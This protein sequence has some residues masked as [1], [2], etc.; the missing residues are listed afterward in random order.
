M[1]FRPARAYFKTAV[2]RLSAHAP[3][4]ARGSFKG[5]ATNQLKKGVRYQK[6]EQVFDMVE[7]WADQRSY[8]LWMSD[9]LPLDMS[10]PGGSDPPDRWT[11]QM[12]IL[13]EQRP[14]LVLTLYTTASC[15]GSKISTEHT[16]LKARDFSARTAQ[17]LSSSLLSFFHRDF[18]LLPCSLPD[19][20]LNCANLQL[21]VED[22]MNYI[23]RFYRGP[24]QLTLTTYRELTEAVTAAAGVTKVPCFLLDPGCSEAWLL[25]LE[26]DWRDALSLLIEQ[27]EHLDENKKD[28]QSQLLTYTEESEFKVK[29]AVV[30]TAKRLSL[31]RRMVLVTSD[32]K[33]LSSTRRMIRQ[34]EDD[35]EA[36][37]LV[38]VSPE[39][40]Q[41]SA[42]QVIYIDHS[43]P[44]TQGPSLFVDK[45]EFRLLLLGRTG[46]GRS[47]TGN[48]ILGEKLFRSSVPGSF[49]SETSKCEVNGKKRNGIEIKVMDSPGLFD[50]SKDDKTISVEVRKAVVGMHGG[51]DAVLYVLKIGPYT[52]E[53]LGVYKRLK[54]ILGD[55]IKNYM[56]VVFTHGDLLG[57]KNIKRFLDQAPKGL[58]EV[59][60]DCNERYVVFNN[61][62]PEKTSQV[63]RLL[64]QVR[65]MRA[66]NGARPYKCEWRS[67][68]EIEREL[69]KIQASERHY[70]GQILPPPRRPT[71]DSAPRKKRNGGQGQGQPPLRTEAHRKFV[72]SIRAFV[73]FSVFV[74]FIVWSRLTETGYVHWYFNSSGL[75]PLLG[76]TMADGSFHF[77][78]VTCLAMMALFLQATPTLAMPRERRS[79]D[80][81][82]LDV[83]VNGLSEKLTQLTAQ[84]QAVET[85]LAS[86]E[87]ANTQIETKL[88]VLD[89]PVVFTVRFRTL[90]V[91]GLGAGQTLKFDDVR[92]NA[93]G[94]YS[95]V[96]GLFTAPSSG[97]YAFFLEA[98]VHGDHGNNSLE[99][100]ILKG[101]S[102]IANAYACCSLN[103]RTS[104]SI[105][106]HLNQGDTV[107]VQI[108]HGTDLYG[109][110][111]TS[112]TGIK[113]SPN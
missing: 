57:G 66:Q 61:T 14:A 75:S 105:T 51:L 106:V 28:R 83:V 98:M 99:L 91:T 50:T 102:T 48:T 38:V 37:S 80:Y 40:K 67:D 69:A 9:T 58:R 19:D 24:K 18:V 6:S 113:L 101:S 17:F 56:I 76:F 46:S 95:P 94:G 87:A 25:L 32:E 43:G 84:L 26:A 65:K 110:R 112:F 96:N 97:S 88:D 71:E 34:A 20:G 93:G 22:R 108:A 45:N 111:H 70:N 60:A 21:E 3:T 27:M 79:D 82:A 74:V 52:E 8:C 47:T 64:E 15:S 100:A 53:E 31:R 85:R 92:Y 12:I 29:A 59:L 4:L 54:A 62:I 1:K 78:L 30:E 35:D 90:H 11:V 39:E 68:E 36:L 89:H 49:T 103:A 77:F 16:K 23:S 86:Q 109:Q 42:Q 13:C 107:H 7:E 10:L 2:F 55:D 73:L 5:K 41:P 104:Q 81:G 72:T 33:L 63:D 44:C